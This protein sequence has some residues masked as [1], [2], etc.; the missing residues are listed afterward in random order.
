MNT[1]WLG[2]TLLLISLIISALIAANIK[3]TRFYRT[4]DYVKAVE[5]GQFTPV[6]DRVVWVPPWNSTD[7]GWVGFDILLQQE[8]PSYEA[9]GL[10]MPNDNDTTP[11]LAMRVVNRTGLGMLVYDQFDP[12]TWKDTKI[13]AAADLF[14]PDR[15]YARFTFRNLDDPNSTYTVLFRNYKNETLDRPFLINIKHAWGEPTPAALLEP[16][17][18]YAIIAAVTATIGLG[19]VIRN[20]RS[21]R[22]R[23]LHKRGF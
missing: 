12:S 6:I 4:E 2:L 15:L 11:D 16:T 5:D 9:Y 7:R 23:R 3:I 13:Y 1:R 20:P 22:K 19:L 21:P 10:V 8:K 17:A 14:P 18:P